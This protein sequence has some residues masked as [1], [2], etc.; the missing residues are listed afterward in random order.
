MSRY[1]LMVFAGACSFGILSTFVKLAYVDGY[2]AAEISFSQAGMGMMV[3]WALS[4]LSM[5]RS[6]FRLSAAGWASLLLTG[7]FIGLTTFVYYVSV[8]YIPASLAIVLLMQF[9][10]MGVLLDWLLFKKKPTR[11]QLLVTGLVILGTL[12]SAGLFSS[13]VEP[14][15]LTGV[16]YAL[17]SALLY[18][19]YVVA[20]SRYGNHLHPLQKSAVIMTGSMLGIFL[21]N[22][23]LLAG[24]DHFD[25][26]LLKW[27]LFLSL[28]GTIIPPVLF[29]KG[30]P[31][32]GAGVSAVVMTAELP[33][34]VICSHLVLNEQITGLQWLGVAVMLVAIALLN[35]RRGGDVPG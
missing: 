24:S 9:S 22:A 2:T 25:T 8:K 5:K 10:W 31:R 12:L 20:N 33:V 18:A 11:Q 32:I 30:I 1:I 4:L 16:L 21:V 34:A 26:G 13:R 3:L 6:P 23:Q 7:A 19:V 28:F 15:S 14:V 27:T 35:A 17:L 29:S